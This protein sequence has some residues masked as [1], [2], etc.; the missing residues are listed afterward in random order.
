MSPPRLLAA[1]AALPAHHLPR[2]PIL[3]FVFLAVHVP[4][5]HCNPT[6]LPTTY[7]D[8]ICSDSF[9]CGSVSI[10]YPFYLSNETRETADYSGYYYCGYTDLEISCKDEGP[11]ETPAIFLGGDEYT[12]LNI[13]YGGNSPTVI[14]A[15]SD[16]LVGGSCPAVRHGVTF[17]EAPAHSGSD[18][19]YQAR[20][21]LP[22]QQDGESSSMHGGRQPAYPLQDDDALL[23]GQLLHQNAPNEKEV[24]VI[25]AMFTLHAKVLQEAIQS[26]FN[27][28]AKGSTRGMISTISSLL[29]DYIEKACDMAAMLGSLK[30]TLPPENEALPSGGAVMQSCLAGAASIP[31]RDAFARI[32]SV[33]PTT[34]TLATPTA[35]DDTSIA[36]V[37]H[38]LRRIEQATEVTEPYQGPLPSSP[39]CNTEMQPMVNENVFDT[40]LN[41]G[42]EHDQSVPINT[43]ASTTHPA[44]ISATTATNDDDGI[45]QG[46]RAVSG[47]ANFFTTPSLSVLQPPSAQRAPTPTPTCSIGTLPQNNNNNIQVNKMASNWTN[48]TSGGYG[49]LLKQGFE[50]E[51][52]RITTD[53]CYRCEQSGGKCSYSQNNSQN[54]T[55]L[56][57][58]CSNR[59]V[60]YPDCSS[61]GA[62]ASTAPASSKPLNR[63]KYLF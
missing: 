10:S 23:S 27:C 14:L 60:A 13:S 17:D 30:A 12:V 56:G 45:P 33:L 31:A 2:L 29:H 39:I 53:Q 18:E 9:M 41:I 57:C 50:L 51:W 34:S 24:N 8:S 54:K 3:L 36:A 58:L 63:H 52:S 20:E 1:M 11:N 6:L 59:K 40:S 15:D 32:L 5:S 48:F 55:F 4:A 46:S 21:R 49:C 38:V 37:E 28:S 26:L 35:L 16:V 61:K 7:D 19:V 47:I 22:C 62:S 43:P 25:Q 44:E 42:A